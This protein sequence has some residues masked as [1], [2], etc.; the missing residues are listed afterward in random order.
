MG[1]P[2]CQTTSRRPASCRYT[3]AGRSCRGLPSQVRGVADGNQTIAKRQH[4]ADQPANLVSVAQ[5]DGLDAGV[6][7]QELE[8][9]VWIRLKSD[10]PV[11][12]ESVLAADRASAVGDVK[13]ASSE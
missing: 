7:S 11:A 10:F 4:L 5:D 12:A 6:D 3:S 13:T 1:A 8:V 2:P 9:K